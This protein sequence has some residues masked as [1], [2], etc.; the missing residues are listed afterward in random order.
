[1]SDG[2]ANRDRA[3]LENALRRAGEGDRAAFRT[4]YEMSSAKL[5]GVCLRICGDRG[6]AEEIL[7]DVYLKVWTRA[8]SYRP[9]EASPISWLCAI[10][11]N[12]AIDWRRRQRAVAPLPDEVAE[13]IPD[14]S[15]RIEED[16]D[17]GRNRARIL[18]CLGRIDRDKAQAIRAAFFGGL[19]YAELAE[20]QDRPLGT[21][22][23][24]IRRGLAQLKDCLEG[25]EQD[26]DRGAEE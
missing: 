17:A 2:A 13:T 14:E 22:K 10:A 12:A 3:A 6:A 5:F 15:V 7:Q 8:G 20:R 23:S 11:R 25:R 16:I 21:I 4:V 26:A 1:M 19:T 9:G 24:W 18:H